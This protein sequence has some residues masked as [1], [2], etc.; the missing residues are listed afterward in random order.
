MLP[1]YL[2]LAS[3]LE[4]LVTDLQYLGSPTSTVFSGL[5][6]LYSSLWDFPSLITSTSIA[7]RVWISVLAV[8]DSPVDCLCWM[9]HGANVRDLNSGSRWKAQM[10]VS[11]ECHCAFEEPAICLRHGRFALVRC[12]CSSRRLRTCSVWRTLLRSCCSTA[13]HVLWTY[14]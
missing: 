6:K 11:P 7:Y 9:P 2:L 3:F 1:S 14:A 4:L 5:H 8:E 12:N 10:Q 13:I